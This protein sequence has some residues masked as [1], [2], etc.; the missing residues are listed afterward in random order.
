[1]IDNLKFDTLLGNSRLMA[2]I[3]GM[4]KERSLAVATSTWKLGIDVVELPIQSKND[5]DALQA[6]VEQ[7]Q[8][9]GKQVGAGTVVT[10]HQVKQAADAG[11]A[12]TVSPGLDLEVARAS[13]EAGLPHLPGVGTA[14]EVQIA[15]KEGLTWLKA[16]PASLLGTAWFLS[17]S[18]PFPDVTF[19]ATGGI[20]AS[21]ASE[22]LK[23]GARVVA[24]GSALEDGTQL[25]KL[26]TLL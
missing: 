14:S 23:A 12:F 26:S 6:V 25:N 7:G 20:N 21:N 4:G 24:V 2:I 17:M 19:V 10:T 16:F 5:L 11:A 8:A 9:C 13:V 1:M 18:S 3:R 15:R 22:F